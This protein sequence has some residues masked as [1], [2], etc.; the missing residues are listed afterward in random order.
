MTE[1][2]NRDRTIF[3]ALLLLAVPSVAHANAGTPLMWAGILH[4]VF[5]NAIIGVAEGLVLGLLFRRSKWK[6]I[7]IMIVANYFSAWLGYAT[8]A[9]G[10]AE[11]L[12]MDLHSAWQSIWLMVLIAY[13]LTLVLELPF[14]ILALAGVRF[15]LPKAL[16]GSLVVQ[17]ASYAVL[18]WW[19]WP[20][21]STSLFAETKVVEIASVPLPENVIVYFIS[22]DDGDVYA[23]SLRDAEWRRV[24]D[25][26]SVGREDRLLVRPSV[27]D[28]DVW[29]IVVRLETDDRWEPEFILVD[30][31]LASAAP[32]WRDEM[33]RERYQYEGTWSNFGWIPRLGDA[34]SSPWKFWTGFWPYEGL[35]GENA[36]SGEVAGFAMETPFV[37]WHVR[38]ATHLPT[39]KVLLQLGDDQICVYDPEAGQVALLARGR[40]PIA[41]MEDYAPNRVIESGD[42]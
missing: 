17:T 32:T 26:N 39:D 7:L 13:L 40:G 1:R 42:E 33:D 28:P 41:V 4:M 29:E 6:C 9:A 15:W 35:G 5:G 31:L 34:Q 38:N 12:P 25:V 11:S 10:I 14:V 30:H 22:A 18:I 20:A 36:R 3:G 37:A 24:F 8:I 16:L 21:S 27:E 19:Y 23:G 2:A